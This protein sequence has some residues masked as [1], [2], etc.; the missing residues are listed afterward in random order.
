MLPTAL[1]SARTDTNGAYLWNGTQWVQLV[2]ASS[3]PAAFVAANP[4]SSGQ[5]VYEI[6]IAP[7]NTNIFYMQFDGYIFKSV[8]KGATWTQTTFSQQTADNAND[9]YGQVGQKMAIDPKQPQHRLCG[10]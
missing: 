7:S 3:M 8:N 4:V 1:W 2:T 5:G 6:Q 10:D 9:S